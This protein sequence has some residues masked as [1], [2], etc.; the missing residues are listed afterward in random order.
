MNKIKN[1]FSLQFSKP[2]WLRRLFGVHPEGIAYV[3]SKGLKFF[4]YLGDLYGP[5]YHLMHWGVDSYESENQKYISRVLSNDSVF[6]D[7]GANVGIYSVLAAME[8]PNTK[9]YAFEPDSKSRECI[10]A[11]IDHNGL[12]NIK[13]VSE[14]L[15]D[16]EGTAVFYMDQNNHGGNSL[17]KDSI[18]NVETAKKVSVS[19]TTMD[20]FVKKEDLK[21]IDLIKI[22]VQEHEVEVLNG[23][24]ETL[25]KFRPIV[26]IECST[27][28]EGNK[29]PFQFFENADYNVFDPKSEKIYSV[30][31]ARKAL[32]DKKH[33]SDHAY[34]DFFFFPVEKKHYFI[35]DRP[36]LVFLA[37]HLS[38]GGS[39]RALIEY[40][41]CIDREKYKL[42]LILRDELP[43]NYLL[44]SVPEYVEI[45]TI[46]PDNEKLSWFAQWRKN[47]FA[48]LDLTIRMKKAFLSLPKESYICDFSSVLIKLAYHFPGY[49]KIYWIHG[50]KSHMDELELRKFGLRL[51][52]YDLILA[53]SEHL[54]TEMQTLLPS[55]KEKVFSLY[56]P[57]DIERI[58]ESANDDSDLSAEDR[59]LIK[60][61]YILAVGR[62][63][64]E[65][66]FITLI[67]AYSILKNNGFDRKLYIVG[68]GPR[69][70]EIKDEIKKENLEQDIVLLG[71]RPNPYIWMKNAEMFVHSAFLEGFG[72][73]LVEAMALQK[74]VVVT[75]SPVGPREVLDNGKYGILVP[76]KDPQQM[77]EAI[78]KLFGEPDAMR[79]YE[80]LSLSRAKDFQADCILGRFDQI[81]K[82]L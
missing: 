18:P 23:A 45:K 15:S 1:F 17:N 27:L 75:D 38:F 35:A 8:G 3:K 66:D 37:E 28:T 25:K 67:Q 55:L 40:L 59:R 41:S 57:F 9:V 31:E 47:N 43:D 68:D 70:Q 42:C 7:V 22:D 21:K 16:R 6:L 24:I 11:N 82:S 39:E 72:L 12:N 53:V 26:L 54:K 76:V 65:K 56:N 36:H 34:I 51:R 61:K 19:L 44:S 60:G 50:P 13:I 74:A 77:A 29:D 79:D 48:K 5:S 64:A 62:F 73:V 71:A 81:I 4:L 10:Q 78:L 46:Y 30:E 2:R 33:T 49:K 32:Q 14:A 20:L 63:A 52:A 69:R 58:K 80:T